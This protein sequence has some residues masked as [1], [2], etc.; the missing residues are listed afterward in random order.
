MSTGRIRVLLDDQRTWIR[1]DENCHSTVT[2][3]GGLKA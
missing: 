2:T 1:P 3:Y